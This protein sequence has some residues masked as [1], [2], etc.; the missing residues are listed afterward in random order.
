MYF[1]DTQK[2]LEDFLRRPA[3]PKELKKHNYTTQT[4]GIIG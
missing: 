1:R 3:V 4:H 2:H